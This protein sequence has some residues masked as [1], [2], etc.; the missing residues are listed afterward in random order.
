MVR[1][2]AG[3][4][5]VEVRQRG[6]GEEWGD[7]GRRRG[8]GYGCGCGCGVEAVPVLGVGEKEEGGDEEIVNEDGRD[9]VCLGLRLE[10]GKTTECG[11][12]D[13]QP[14]AR[15]DDSRL[16]HGN[17]GA[18]RGRALEDALHAA[19][20]EG[21]GMARDA[22]LAGCVETV[23]LEQLFLGEARAVDEELGGGGRAVFG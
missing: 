20:F 6:A 10:R 11:N 14:G 5:D 23:P 13:V 8:C 2:G 12:K 16:E 3:R 19:P 15:C 4:R 18:R 9:A 22:E 21:V 1:V 7:E 17:G